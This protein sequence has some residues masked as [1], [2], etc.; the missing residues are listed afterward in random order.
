MFNDYLRHEKRKKADDA[1]DE[2]RIQLGNRAVFAAS[3]MGNPNMAR[4]R[5]E[6]VP[7]PNPMYR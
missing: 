3:L 5:C 1:V 6:T 7:M 2:I 4:D